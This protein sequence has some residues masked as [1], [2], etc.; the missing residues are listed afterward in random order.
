M[1]SPVDPDDHGLAE[2]CVTV[3]LTVGD[4]SGSN[5]ER[6]EMHVF[7]HGS[8]RSNARRMDV[9]F[10]MPGT[11]NYPF[12][13]GKKYDFK[14]KWIASN[15]AMP[16][17]D[18]QAMICN[19]ATEG[20]HAAILNTGVVHVDDPDGLLTYETHGDDLNT[21]IGKEGSLEV[22]GVKFKPDSAT[23]AALADA[24]TILPGDMPLGGSARNAVLAS[25][26]EDDRREA[27]PAEIEAKVGSPQKSSVKTTFID[28]LGNP[29][30][31]KIVRAFSAGGKL[32]MVSMASFTDSNGDARIELETNF[33]TQYAAGVDR[34][35]VSFLAGFAAQNITQNTCS[36]ERLRVK[37]HVNDFAKHTYER[38]LDSPPVSSPATPAP[39]GI[40]FDMPIINHIQLRNIRRRRRRERGHARRASPRARSAVERP[41]GGS[42]GNHPRVHQQL[43]F[44]EK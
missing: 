40:A 32:S 20:F 13:K 4:P 17:Y 38:M 42:A 22:P 21:A 18:W 31:N 44:P 3:P 19:S 24:V 30:K 41:C 26:E 12:V 28:A 29:K 11:A 2:N 25:G 27:V 9:T 39:A 7:E 43:A 33:Q 5:S 35:T 14:L 1:S 36:D 23:H 16:D 15:L 37:T 6:W 10:G 34:E 8:R